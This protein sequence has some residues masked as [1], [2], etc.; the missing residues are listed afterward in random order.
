MMKSLSLL[1]LVGGAV[2]QKPAKSVFIKKPTCGHFH[3]FLEDFIYLVLI[4][5]QLVLISVG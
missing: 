5:A 3:A 2:A 4:S 1:A